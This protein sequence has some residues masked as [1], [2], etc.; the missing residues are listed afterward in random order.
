MWSTLHEQHCTQLHAGQVHG[1]SGEKWSPALS[2]RSQWRHHSLAGQWARSQPAHHGVPPA[3]GSEGV[4][5]EQLAQRGAAAQGCPLPLLC[6]GQHW[7]CHV[8]AGRP[9][10][11]WR[12]LGLKLSTAVLHRCSCKSCVV[13]QMRA[14][15]P[16]IW[17]TGEVRSQNT[18]NCWKDGR[19]PG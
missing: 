19:R 12:Y 17:T 2:P 3:A 10:Q 6:W 8:W 11:Y 9:P 16:G 7:K 15:H 18:G 14:F 13:W 1:V 5:C 4:P